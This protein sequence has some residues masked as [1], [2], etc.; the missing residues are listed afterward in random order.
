MLK[1]R[2][3][4]ACQWAGVYHRLKSSWVYD[5]YWTLADRSLIMDMAK[6]VDFYRNLLS[7][8]RSGDLIFDIGAN[9]GSKT[10]LFLRLAARVVAVDPDE[11]NKRIL[12]EKFLKY[13]LTPKPVTVINKAVSDRSATETLWIDV[14]GSAKNTLSLKWVETLRVD[15]ARF[16]QTLKFVHQRKI[17]TTTLEELIAA[18]GFPFFVKIDVEGH[19]VSVLRGLKRAVPNLSFEVNLPEFRAEG[20]ECVALLGDLAAEGR[21]NYSSDCRRGLT[22]KEWVEPEAFSAVLSRCDE[23]CIEVF[24]KSSPASVR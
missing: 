12:E 5:A 4:N 13:R 18:H 11:T 8:F 15:A 19:E 20:L 1:P 9:Q 16:G 22:L 24:W 21:F 7:G 17:E 6:E 3:Q 23:T 2:I 10:D 14:P